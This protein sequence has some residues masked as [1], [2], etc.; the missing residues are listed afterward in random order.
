[1]LRSFL[2]PGLDLVCYADDTLVLPRGRDEEE[3]LKRASTGTRLVVNRIR[4]L[5]LSVALHKTQ[6][7]LVL[8]ASAQDT[9]QE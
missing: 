2:P 8:R 5:G 1:M 4:R 7:P 9:G 6:G 3:A